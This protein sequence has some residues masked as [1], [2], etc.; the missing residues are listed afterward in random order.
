MPWKA[1]DAME[2]RLEF[3]LRAKQASQ[4][5]A[6]L[7]REY[8]ISRPTGYLW[9]RRYRQVGSVLGLGERSRR[10]RHSPRRTA[11]QLEA[12]VVELRQRHGWGARKLRVLLAQQGQQLLEVTINRILQR[13]GLVGCRSPAGQ[14]TRRFERAE[15]NQLAQ[16]DFKGEYA[17]RQ[18]SCYPLSMLDDHSR[19]LLGLWPLPSPNGQAV[20]AALEGLFRAQ[21]VPQALLLDHGSPWWS[22]S[23]GHGLTRLS[24]WLLGQNIRV[25]FAGLRHPQTQ[26]KVERFHRTLKERTRHRGLPASLAEWQDWAQEFRQEYNELRPHEALGMRTPDPGLPAGQPAALPGAAAALGLWLGLRA[27]A[28]RAGFCHLPRRSLLRVRG[29]GW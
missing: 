1:K 25:L 13:H 14:A 27:G 19:Y 6:Q 26:G 23:N 8:G 24:V 2:L 12:A 15:C 29:A 20:R 22:P 11:A 9:V 16:V 10:P 3:V 17:L 28:Q 5:F 7:C 4:P 18:G 21:G